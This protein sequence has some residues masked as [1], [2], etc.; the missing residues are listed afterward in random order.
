MEFEQEYRSKQR[1]PIAEQFLVP[2][3]KTAKRYYR[4]TG[5]FSTSAL[6]TW[7]ASLN[8]LI[9]G[10]FEKIKLIGSPNLSARDIEMFKSLTSR[11]IIDQILQKS[12]DDILQGIIDLTEVNSS[13]KAGAEVFSWLYAMERIEIKFALWLPE[14]MQNIEVEN[15]YHKKSGLL[16]FE[17]DTSVAFTG[18]MN[19]T[20]SGHAVNYEEIDVYRSWVPSE[21]GRINSKLSHFERSWNGEIDGLKVLSPSRQLCEQLQEIAENYQKSASNRRSSPNK[22]ENKW[23]HQVEARSWFLDKRIG[24]LEMATG[25][26]KTRTALSIAKALIEKG[27]IVTTIIT[28]DGT[29]LL[30]QWYEDL[31]EWKKN[32]T[33]TPPIFRMYSNYKQLDDFLIHPSDSIILISRQFLA[34]LLPRIAEAEARKTLI[35]HDEAHGVG[36]PTYIEK[37][38]GF[39]H[40]IS[41]QIS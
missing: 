39:A 14:N 17:D 24:L 21:V 34:R 9:T 31:I 16:F 2:A 29:D 10:E 3:L 4:E 38:S 8:R 20:Y 11:E 26:G 25:T 27:E 13:H 5:Y 32:I 33:Q 23:R 6:V 15:L 12:A 18:S 36:A 19:E 22:S 41:L 35:I 40:Y 7:V 30:N 1:L 28:M 37:F